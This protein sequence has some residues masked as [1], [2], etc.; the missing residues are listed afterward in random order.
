MFTIE[1]TYT[2][3]STFHTSRETECIE[4]QWDDFEKVKKAMTE[5]L[6]FIDFHSAIKGFSVNPSDKKSILS[7]ASKMPWASDYEYDLGAMMIEDNSGI[8]KYLSMNFCTGYF[9]NLESARI[10]LTKTSG[11][12]YDYYSSRNLDLKDIQRKYGVRKNG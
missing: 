8:R 7:L 11:I 2:T 10:V 1:V 4:F 12:C 3:G 9:E 5:M 6:E